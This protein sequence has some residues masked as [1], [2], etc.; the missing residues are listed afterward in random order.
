MPEWPKRK[1]QLRGTL[2]SNIGRPMKCHLNL[3]PS[4]LLTAVSTSL[5]LWGVSC[6]PT[7]APPSIAE[8]LQFQTALHERGAG[9]WKSPTGP[10]FVYTTN[11]VGPY[12][13]VW[14]EELGHLKDRP[15]VQIL[16]IGS[17]EGRS[18]N[19]FL[20][21]IATHPTSA[22]TC[23]DLF[24]PR[25][26]QFFDHNIRVGGNEEQVTKLQGKSQEVLRGLKGS[27]DVV[28]VDACHLATCAISDIVLSWHLLKLNG[29]MII[30]DYGW[31]QPL[32][33]DRPEL[34]VDSFLQIFE[35]YIE[36]RHK[37]YQVIVAK[38]SEA[39]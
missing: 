8:R 25:L 13:Q 7:G 17:F 12:A 10:Y 14:L 31:D 21:N 37:G 36:V 34:A 35:P 19:W 33:V 11:W 18:A 5:V 28:Y 20:D 4:G 2:K 23:V 24:P 30:D 27:F 3:L 22:I 26:D 16:E 39:Y 9:D 1:S 29:L 6:S 32:L 15:D 38:T